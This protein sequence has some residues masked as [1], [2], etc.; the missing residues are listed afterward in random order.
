MTQPTFDQLLA[1][2][3]RY[4]PEGILESAGSLDPKEQERLRNALKEIK[5]EKKV[6][7]GRRSHR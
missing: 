3:H 5:K 4:G 6:K 7:H 2:A 1:H